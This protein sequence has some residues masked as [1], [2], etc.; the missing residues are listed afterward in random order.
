[1]FDNNT[2]DFNGNGDLE[3]AERS[4][5]DEFLIDGFDEEEDDNGWGNDSI[6]DVDRD[7]DD[8]AKEED[9]EVY[10]DDDWNYVPRSLKGKEERRIRIVL[11]IAEKLGKCQREID[12]IKDD[13]SRI[14]DETEDLSSDLTDA[15]ED[16]DE[17]D[18]IESDLEKLEEA[19]SG[20]EE[21]LSDLA[22]VISDLEDIEWD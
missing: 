10:G 20:L 19:E 13:L 22:S 12:F 2:F 15:Q 9:A 17:A 14:K 16:T 6:D 21:L 18:K 11:R 7:E 1:M 4:F 5:R 3:P 8:D